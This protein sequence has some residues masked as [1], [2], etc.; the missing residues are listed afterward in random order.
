VSFCVVT[1]A[2]LIPE[3]FTTNYNSVIAFG[4]AY[5]VPDNERQEIFIKFIEK[6]SK[7]HMEAGLKYIKNS[8]PKAKLFKIEI[9][10][11]TAKGK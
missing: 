7:N 3:D 10:H 11:M 2:L 8:G 9:E 6:F 4:K 5:E 1:D